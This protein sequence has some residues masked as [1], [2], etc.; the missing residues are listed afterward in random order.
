MSELLEALKEVRDRVTWATEFS[1]K[2]ICDEGKKK[3]KQF[4]LKLKKKK[5]QY[6]AGAYGKSLYLPFNFA[7]KVKLL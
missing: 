4:V 7:M 1:L 2:T 3:R 6:V 5:K